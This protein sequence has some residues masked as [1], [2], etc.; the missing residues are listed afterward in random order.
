MMKAGRRSHLPSPKSR[1]LVH[2]F[3]TPG[4][5]PGEHRYVVR[6]RPW[7]SRRGRSAPPQDRLF[8][9]EWELI[10][11]VNPLLPRGSDV[12]HVL[13]YVE[14][15]EGFL[16]LLHLNAEQA[17]ALGWQGQSSRQSLEIDI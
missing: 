13:S 1:Y 10:Q 14:S 6:I 3:C 16:Y 4:E 11:A 2:L 12:R 15:A 17:S 5:N 8:E 9:S 7:T